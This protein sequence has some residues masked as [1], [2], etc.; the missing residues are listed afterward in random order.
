MLNETEYI[1]ACLSEECSE[2][3]KLVDKALRFGLHDHDFNCKDKITNL[4]KIV[5]EL[6]D[7]H[8]VCRKMDKMHIFELKHVLHEERIIQ[9]VKK[10]EWFM[11][12]SRKN[13]ALKSRRMGGLIGRFRRWVYWNNRRLEDV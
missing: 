1:L 13:G 11:N 7:I 12:Y 3:I 5:M 9:K 4:D 8:G 6:T 10:I 2:V